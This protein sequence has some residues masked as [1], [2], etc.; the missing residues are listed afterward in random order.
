LDKQSRFSSKQ[1]FA[2]NLG[3]AGEK[4]CDA[5]KPAISAVAE[6]A[7]QKTEL[8]EEEAPV[9]KSFSLR[10]VFCWT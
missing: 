7:D 10:E 1:A 4:I 9:Q 3:S 6:A 2:T 5:Q 8:I